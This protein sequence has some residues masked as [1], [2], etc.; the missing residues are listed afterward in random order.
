MPSAFLFKDSL[1]RDEILYKKITTLYDKWND[2]MMQ[3][4]KIT[5]NQKDFSRAVVRFGLE[6]LEKALN[7]GDK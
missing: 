7:N 3:R 2:Q 6:A 4:S 5:I 1:L